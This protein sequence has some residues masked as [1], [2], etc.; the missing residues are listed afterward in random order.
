[1]GKNFLTSKTLWVNA[2]G[3]LVL[4]FGPDIVSADVQ[5]G[6]LA[7]I[8]MILRLVTKEPIVWS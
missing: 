8:N 3:I 2:I 6:A 1:M 7:I 5:V 4:L